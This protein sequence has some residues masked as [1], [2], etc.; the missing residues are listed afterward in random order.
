MIE[1]A[2]GRRPV[3]ELQVGDLVLTL[4]DGY[5]PIRWIGGRHLDSIDLAMNPKL[6]PIRIRAGALGEGLPLRDLVV[7]PQHR[8]L[9]RSRVARNMFGSFEV[10]GAAK[11]FLLCDG[12]DVAE[13]LDGVSY[14][15]FMFDKHQIVYS[16]GAATESLYTGPEAL[17]AVDPEA[18]KEIQAILP[19]LLEEQQPSA[20]GRPLLTGRQ[21]RKLAARYV[22]KQRTI[23]EDRQPAIPA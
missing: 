9:A 19:E 6:R 11:Q 13:D 18:V 8:I 10:L 3:E 5:Q 20:G 16:E 2:E 21:A 15:H 23:V 14:W 22:K 4:D 1:T 7:S 17:K 12:I